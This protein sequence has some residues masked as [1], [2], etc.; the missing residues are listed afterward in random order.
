MQDH[1]YMQ[2]VS[3]LQSELD[4]TELVVLKGLG[5]GGFAS[6]YLAYDQYLG[7]DVAIKFLNRIT[8]KSLLSRFKRE[9]K[10][11]ASM[12]HPNILKVYR[13]GW[14]KKEV[15]YLVGEFLQGQ[16]L[17]D[18]L[19]E[20]ACIPA[21]ESIFLARQ[22]AAGMSYAESCR[23]V[24]RDLKPENIILCQREKEILLK[25]LDF[26][27]CK[28]LE[29]SQGSTG[30]K[31]ATGELLG[32]PSYMSPEQCL[33][34]TVDIRSDIYAFACIF[35]EMLTGEKLFQGYSPAEVILKQL[36]GGEKL[37]QEIFSGSRIPEDLSKLLAACL[38]RDPEQRPPSFA[39]IVSE[40]DKLDVLDPA[41]KF[42][43][44]KRTRKRPWSKALLAAL[45][46][47]VLITI[48]VLVFKWPELTASCSTKLLA[49]L[50]LTV[51]LS[52]CESLFQ[53]LLRYGNTQEAAI[54]ISKFYT[55]PQYKELPVFL[56][57]IVLT[58]WCQNLRK[59]S[60]S[61][62][63]DDHSLVLLS[64]LLQFFRICRKS[65]DYHLNSF[66]LPYWRV[67]SKLGST[68]IQANLKHIDTDRYRRQVIK[69]LEPLGRDGALSFGS[70]ELGDLYIQAVSELRKKSNGDLE[71]LAQAYLLQ[72]EGFRRFPY[73]YGRSASLTE[74]GLL[75]KVRFNSEKALETIAAL[76]SN[77]VQ[78]TAELRRAKAQAY[79]YL[80]LCAKLIDKNT[81]QANNYLEKAEALDDGSHRLLFADPSTTDLSWEKL[82]HKIKN[83]TNSVKGNN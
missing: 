33:G 74:T 21:N 56:R 69:V 49:P 8:D 67:L 27:L 16:T 77:G 19:K 63:L 13:L 30:F 7:R 20:K 79:L 12:E 41:I 1:G 17:A 65:G 36:N 42:E 37:V 39:E 62:K 53:T 73:L 70:S 22:I 35:C 78:L 4:S 5:Q 76:N 80:G 72:A 45:L 28:S 64:D 83:G 14:T 26:G 3:E 66:W 52:L 61:I 82:V 23:V 51:Q 55:Q 71:Q 29:N 57:C 9:A 46:A 38:R 34:K 32:T 59:K 44:H 24:H 40:I 58:S 6:V 48:L 54:L 68:E 50:P 15:P 47:G 43:K 75:E 10:I 2:T 25:I 11:L 60:Q 31:T 81:S 18:Y